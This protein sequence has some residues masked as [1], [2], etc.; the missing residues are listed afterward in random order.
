MKN[1]AFAVLLLLFSSIASAQLKVGSNPSQINKSSILEL[2]SE[3]QGL[4]LPR[5][6]GG[7]LTTA[8]L[9]TA[10]D[11]MIIYVLDS[12]SLFI[13]KNNLW[14]RMSADSV[15]N[16]SNWNIKGNAGLDSAI[17]FLGSL[18]QQPLIFK[19]NNTERLRVTGAGSIKV[20]PGTIA[21]GT[22][23][24]QVLVI[25]PVT[26]TLLQRT[27]S[28]A[29][30]SNAIVSLNGQRDSV[31][32]FR[33]DSAVTVD[34][35]INSAAGVHTFN[36]PTQNGNGTTSRGLLSLSDWTRFD[37]AA[38]FRILKTGFATL[39]NPSG[40]SIA[41]D[42][43]KLHPADATNPGG[44]SIATQTFGGAKNF[45]DS[46]T[47]G[48]AQGTAANSTFQVNG[49][50]ATN[51]TNKT[52]NYTATAADNTILADASGGAFTITL[53]SPSGLNGRMYTIKKIGTGGIDNAVTIA[54]TAGSIDGGSSY[55]IYNDWTFVTLQT[56]GTNWYVIKK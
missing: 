2:E 10:P 48:L 21:N 50:M 46:L 27:M 3:R 23:Q 14:Q 44:V 4:L 41:S 56:D 30:F 42:S 53:P 15:G 36:L 19:T 38:R 8:P 13:R 31:Q 16:S 47:V 20:A 35:A 17:N 51:I 54:P 33:V 5:I 9:N 11:G 26:G 49:S 12:A 7:N 52:A 25:D 40:I 24:V 1:I 28:A 22:D 55:I 29:A 18:N 43:I 45:R 37:S 39:T 34:L 32:T 6:P